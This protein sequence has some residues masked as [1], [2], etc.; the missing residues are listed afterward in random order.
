M[1]KLWTAAMPRLS[2]EEQRAGIVLLR[3]LAGGEP[4]GA[5]QLARALGAS[6]EEAEAMLTKSALR[7]FVYAGKDGRVVGFWGLSTRPTHHQF[8]IN[9]RRLWTWCA[10]DSLFLP[11]LLGG[12]AQAESRDPEA[13]ELIRLTI[14]PVGVEAAEPKEV[15]VSMVRLDTADLSSAE[16]IMA[17]A[18]HFIHF[19][20]SRATG[21]RWVTA[22]PQTALLSLYEAIAFGR[23]QN[24]LLFGQELARRTRES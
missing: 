15:V 7:P 10:Q 14:S 12:T 11:E 3:E 21:E 2:P 19:F 18:C 8:T 6:L 1:R 23:R 16:Q 22:Q 9:G 13:G 4:I 5:S 17:T 24:A 20:A